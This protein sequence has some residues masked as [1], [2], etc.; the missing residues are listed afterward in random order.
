MDLRPEKIYG[1]RRG[2]MRCRKGVREA[3]GWMV[4]DDERAVGQG[5]GFLADI[6]GE[7]VGGFSIVVFRMVSVG[8][9]E[10]TRW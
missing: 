7:A 5:E 1:V 3:Y 8:P 6:D 4:G 9:F 10:R 2:E